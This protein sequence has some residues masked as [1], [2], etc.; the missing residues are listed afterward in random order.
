MA[1]PT[2]TDLRPFVPCRDFAL[3]RAFYAAIGWAVEDVA[4]DLALVTV[5]DRQHLYLQDYY[6]RE[7]A[8]NFMLHLTVDDGAAWFARIDD[9]L[10]DGRFAPARVQPP[11]RQDYGAST[12]FV[13]DPSGVLLHLCEWDRPSG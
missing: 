12:T 4:P 9:A 13:H 10:R 2:A 7:F 5:G 8:E 11:R 1:T 3:S 6:V